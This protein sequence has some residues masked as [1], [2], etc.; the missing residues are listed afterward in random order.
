MKRYVRSVVVAL[1]LGLMIP[2]LVSAVKEKSPAEE[3]YVGPF[4]RDQY[5]ML[6]K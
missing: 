6:G 3:V 1:L 4:D 2:F 5:Y